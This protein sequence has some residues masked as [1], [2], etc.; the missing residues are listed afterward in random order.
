MFRTGRKVSSVF[1]FLFP[2]VGTAKCRIVPG[3]AR[4]SC[5][6]VRGPHT[7]DKKSLCE[8][9]FLVLQKSAGETVFIRERLD[10]KFRMEMSDIVRREF[11]S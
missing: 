7:K 5:L 10:D 11:Q 1:I 9:V 8:D 2:D 4:P 6:E 3:I